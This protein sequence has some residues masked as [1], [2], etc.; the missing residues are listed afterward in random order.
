M[1][2]LS[3]AVLH[4]IV[5]VAST[6]DMLLVLDRVAAK[7]AV[8]EGV[9]V[10]AAAEALI[11]MLRDAAAANLKAERTRMKL[12]RRERE[13]A[14]LLVSGM[15]NAEMARQLGCTVRTVRA[16]LEN[17]QRKTGTSN[18]TGLLSVV[19]GLDIGV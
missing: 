12:T 5:E 8:L 17:M 18:K 11:V 15:T 19:E 6:E 10:D 3:A 4:T 14:R 13:V 16:H 1:S 9:D 2:E 7:S